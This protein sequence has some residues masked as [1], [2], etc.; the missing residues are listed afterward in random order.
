MAYPVSVFIDTVG[1]NIQT[2]V[3]HGSMITMGIV[4]LRTG[5]IEV[6]PKT[7]IQAF[8][9]FLTLV[10]S[11]VVMNEAAYQTGLLESE[12]FNMF[13]ISPY[14]APELPVYS[15]I[16]SIIPF[17]FSVLIYIVGF[18]AASSIVLLL[19]KAL[20]AIAAAPLIHR[21]PRALLRRLPTVH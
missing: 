2:M 3:W 9:I 20:G 5:Y 17:P 11:A 12:T 14:C 16:Q 6:S 13:F 8:P 19:C 4:L 21:E 7:I 15:L 18:T 1:I 10:L